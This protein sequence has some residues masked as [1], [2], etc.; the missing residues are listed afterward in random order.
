MKRDRDDTDFRKV[1]ESYSHRETGCLF[2]EL[3][4]ERLLL[5]NRLAVAIL[6]QFP[7]TA[8]HML[9]I[10]RRHASTYFDLG[11]PEVN[12][13]NLLL[14]EA[15]ARIEEEDRAVCGFNIGINAWRAAGQTVFHCHIHLIPRR[16]GDVPDPTGGVRHLIP[17]KGFYERA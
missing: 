12:A 7:V 4:T 9:V 15:K 8:W 14:E 16:E 6:D 13:C 17:G 2:C 5:E 11:R 1:A 3:P 10:P